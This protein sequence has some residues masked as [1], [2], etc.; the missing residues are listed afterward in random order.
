MHSTKELPKEDVYLSNL[1]LIYRLTV[2][3]TQGYSII[4]CQVIATFSFGVIAIITVFIIS[5]RELISVRHDTP[6]APRTWKFIWDGGSIG[7]GSGIG[8]WN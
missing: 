5:Y 6:G 7:M 2:R 8:T 4:F 1:L 3:S